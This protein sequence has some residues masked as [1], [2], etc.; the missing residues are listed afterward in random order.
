MGTLLK[1]KPRCQKSVNNGDD[2]IQHFP[3]SKF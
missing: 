1:E 2:M 3:Q